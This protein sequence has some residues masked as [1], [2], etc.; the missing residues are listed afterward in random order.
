MRHIS[1]RYFFITERIEKKEV[2]IEYC[3]AEET[4]INFFANPLQGSLFRN[5][6]NIIMYTEE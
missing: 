5:F 2:S 3:P 1:V 4:I 6:H